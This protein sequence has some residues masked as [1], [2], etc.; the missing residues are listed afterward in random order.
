M[1]TI[2]ALAAL[3]WLSAAAMAADMGQP[4]PQSRRQTDEFVGG[5][6]SPKERRW[7]KFALISLMEAR[8]FHPTKSWPCGG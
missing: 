5:S 1:R 6:Q 2:I 3:L 4:I 7:P 8:G